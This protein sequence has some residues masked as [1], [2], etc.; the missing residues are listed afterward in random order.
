MKQNLPKIECLRDPRNSYNFTDIY[1]RALKL[2][3]FN[4]VG[5]CC[6]AGRVQTQRSNILIAKLM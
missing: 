6:N 5:W 2:R 1:K 4:S 3:K